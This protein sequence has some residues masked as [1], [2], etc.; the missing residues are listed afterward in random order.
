MSNH[1]NGTR[2]TKG[3]TGNVSSSNGG[4]NKSVFLSTFLLT[5]CVLVAQQLVSD[6]FFK[7]SRNLSMSGL[8]NALA[9]VD[10]RNVS[11][12]FMT[13]LSSSINNNFMQ[14]KDEFDQLDAG[15]KTTTSGLSLLELSRESAR[16]HQD[17]HNCTWPFVLVED[18][19]MMGS[20][21]TAKDSDDNDE[22]KF[23]LWAYES[24]TRKIPR[25]VHLA[26]IHDN[27][28]GGPNN[29]NRGRCLHHLQARAVDKWK[30]AMPNYS[31]VLH[32]DYMV[33]KLMNQTNWPAFPELTRVL[34]CVKMRNAMLI[35]IWRALVLYQFGGIYAD[36]DAIPTNNFSEQLIVPEADF[37]SFSDDWN[38]PS[39]WCFAASPGHPAT[40]FTIHEILKRL[41]DLPQ[42]EAPRLVQTTG[43]EALKI[44]YGK[45]FLWKDD[46]H[47]EGKHY[48]MFNATSIKYTRQKAGEC[49]Q[50]DRGDP[51][52]YNATHNWTIGQQ[53]KAD[54]GDVHWTEG[55]LY[56][57]SKTTQR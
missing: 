51:Y 6:V 5:S 23:D 20:T 47:T 1:N 8:M 10:V 39:Q 3:R 9:E 49:I 14:T 35:D 25:V 52:P 21:S 53:V 46:R 54:T 37:F 17:H 32:D 36:M 13:T 56:I 44:G 18:R 24:Q 11:T 55:R 7:S 41:L 4:R 40:Y 12:S 29:P 33:A 2:G 45:A 34:N 28:E 43:P 16:N 50:G 30:K 19:I 57:A 22:A 26:W 27:P 15:D 38:R 42:I 31:V 48:G